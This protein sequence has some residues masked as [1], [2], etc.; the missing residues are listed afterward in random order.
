MREP[1][2]TSFANTLLDGRLSLS[3]TDQSP[4]LAAPRVSGPRRT[5][6]SQK[7][8]LIYERDNVKKKRGVQ[9]NTKTII[10]RKK[11]VNTR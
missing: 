9:K 8:Y 3:P 10:A 5:Y 2:Y 4:E 1:F 7:D 6:I 11:H